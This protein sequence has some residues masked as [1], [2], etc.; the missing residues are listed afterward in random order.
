MNMSIKQIQ[1]VDNFTT[2]RQYNYYERS[3][4]TY[5]RLAEISNPP[6][7]LFPFVRLVGKGVTAVSNLSRSSLMLPVSCIEP[8]PPTI[9]VSTESKNANGGEF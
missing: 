7:C 6:S 8:S 2:P 5:T 4:G 3:W 9:A 1:I